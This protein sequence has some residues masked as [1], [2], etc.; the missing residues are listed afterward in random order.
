MKALFRLVPPALFALLLVGARAV[1]SSPG[2]A[3]NQSVQAPNEDPKFALKW[4]MPAEAVRQIMGRPDEIKPMN[5]PKGKAEIWVFTR[6]LNQR[7][8]RLPVGAVPIMATTYEIDGSCHDKKMGRAHSQQIGETVVY[9]DLHY[10]TL[11]TVEVLM[12]NEH[13][14]TQKVSR[15]DVRH[16][17]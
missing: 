15:Q 12:Y 17:N 1:A 14:V 5:A 3:G 9:G 8:E 16:Y 11:E 13:F 2:L 4:A 6:E 7:V 10:A